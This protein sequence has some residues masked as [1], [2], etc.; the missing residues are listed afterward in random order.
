MLRFDLTHGATDLT[1]IHDAMRRRGQAIPADML[2]PDF[3]PGLV[4]FSN[5]FAELSTC[6]AIG[7]SGVGPIPWTAIKSM[8]HD[9]AIEGEAEAHFVALMR[10][11]DGAYM[12]HVNKPAK[13]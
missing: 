2:R 12:A 4:R 5:A 3:L 11:M 10:A 6:R 9:W 7:M 8:I 13:G 1:D